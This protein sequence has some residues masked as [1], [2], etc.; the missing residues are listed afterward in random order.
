MKPWQVGQGVQVETVAALANGRIVTGCADG[1]VLIWD[2]TVPD[3]EPLKLGHH[4]PGEVSAIQVL[5]DGRII[6]GGRDGR[7]QIWDPATPGLP[8]WVVCGAGL[9]VQA[10]AALRDGRV[11]I[12]KDDGWVHL[13]DPAVELGSLREWKRLRPDGAYVLSVAKLGDSRLILGCLH[14]QVLV[15]DLAAPT[16]PAS[17]PPRIPQEEPR[18]ADQRP[19]VELGRHGGTGYG[20]WQHYQ[21]GE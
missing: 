18:Q 10:M 20:P 5:N 17:L 8:P 16:P 19:Y 1:Q 15:W 9:G 7:V 13:W 14:G 21:T 12:V 4:H 2:S 11:A 6:S 3:H